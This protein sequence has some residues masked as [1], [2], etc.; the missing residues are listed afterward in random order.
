MG[1]D[2]LGERV[3]VGVPGLEPRL[4]ARRQAEHVGVGGARQLAE[5]EPPVGAPRTRH[6]ATGQLQIGDRG[7]Q[8]V[9]G[10][11]QELGPHARAAP[12][13]APTSVTENLLE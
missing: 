7:L 3:L 2:R 5:A 6:R 9:R 1:V 10:D 13:T 12:T 8:P 11:A 4:L